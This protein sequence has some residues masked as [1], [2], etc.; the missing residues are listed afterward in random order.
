M[1]I[2]ER[3]VVRRLCIPVRH[4]H[5]NRL[6]QA[7]HIAEVLGEITKQRQLGGAGIAEDRSHPE[8]TQ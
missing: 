3:G 8:S 1:Q 5:D 7:E 4:G 6:L 2:D